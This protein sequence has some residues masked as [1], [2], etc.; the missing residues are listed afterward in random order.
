MGVCGWWFVILG[1]N[2]LVLVRIP[3]LAIAALPRSC[4]GL[5]CGARSL[6]GKRG[7]GSGC[8]MG[9]QRP[10][11]CFLFLVSCSGFWLGFGECD[12]N[13]FRCWRIAFFGNT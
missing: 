8:V 10:D 7:Q 4:D 2:I 11:F 12:Y 13:A 9:W 6:S 5:W 3:A 1:T